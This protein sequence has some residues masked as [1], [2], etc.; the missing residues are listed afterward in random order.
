MLSNCCP[1]FSE[2]LKIW[3]ENSWNSDYSNSKKF[4]LS[5]RTT[6]LYPVSLNENSYSP[7]FF[8]TGYYFFICSQLVRGKEKE[9]Q[10]NREFRGC[11]GE[12]VEFSSVKSLSGLRFR[13]AFCGPATSCQTW[14]LEFRIKGIQ[15]LDGVKTWFN[16]SIVASCSQSLFELFLSLNR[17]F[18]RLQLLHSIMT[19]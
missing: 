8:P 10:V 14:K 17:N 9:K 5:H 15:V 6:S 16:F 4:D 7:I 2:S 3:W 18:F 12:P 11:C 19:S 1:E 13:C